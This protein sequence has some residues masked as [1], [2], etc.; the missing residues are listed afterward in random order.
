MERIL[1]TDNFIRVHKSFIV[2]KSKIKTLSTA[3]IEFDHYEVPVG[4]K[5]REEAER[6][7]VG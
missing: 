4:G 6:L 2:A 7:I 1:G 3:G 5:Y